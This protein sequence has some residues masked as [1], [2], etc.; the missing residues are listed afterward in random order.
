MKKSIVKVGTFAVTESETGEVTYGAVE[1]LESKKSGGREYSAEPNGEVT[2]IYADG[3][4]VYSVEDNNG[5]T[6]KLVLLALIDK[7]AKDWLGYTVDAAKKAT[8]EY[9]DGKERPH[10]GL[11]IAESTTEGTTQITFYY[12]CQVTKRPTK[13]GKTTEGKFEAQFAEFELAARPRESDSLVCYELEC[14]TLVT[15]VPEPNSQEQGE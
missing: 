11:A 14:S 2:E 15:T 6:I 13:S 12:D 5:Y 4:V 1:W 3:R 10:F 9:A 7:I 8:A